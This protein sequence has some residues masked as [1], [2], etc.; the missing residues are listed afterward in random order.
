M[1]LFVRTARAMAMVLGCLACEI[2]AEEAGADT[3]ARAL[4]TERGFSYRNDQRQ[5]PTWSVHVFK[6]DR[7]RKDLF[8]TS[9]TG[10]P[11]RIGMSTVVE[12]IQTL[13]ASWGTP[14]AAVNGDFYTTE[15]DYRGDPRDVQI[16]NGELISAPAG[17]ASFWMDAD[18]EPHTANVE[19]NLRVRWP[20][21]SL[22]PLGLNELRDSEMVV[23]YS[24]AIGRSTRSS[25]GVELV[26][27]NAPGE[28]WLPLQVGRTIKARVAS[29]HRGGDTPVPRDGLVLSI[30][31]R[32]PESARNR[33]PGDEIQLE[34]RTTP[35]L[36]GVETALG[37]GPTLVRAGKPQTW[38]NFQIRHPRSAMGWNKT[39]FFL[40]QVDGRQPD[41]SVGMTFPELAKYMAELGCEEA[42]N[43][44]G[45]GSAT[46]W[47]LG[48]VVNSPSEGRQRPGANALVVMR[49]PGVSEARRP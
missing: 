7:S 16:R 43:L 10:L 18:G 42:I 21:G 31:S 37:G 27:T 13:P 24:S 39:H 29:V 15:D 17:H 19:S 48:Q 40:V 3:P 11:E 5:D 9:T 44:D 20:D 4:T 1:P 8:L 28:G 32:M 38:S 47:V 12:Q 26:L 49:R 34:F 14:I 33:Q 45:G 46:M 22:H 41:L 2:R 30:G 6:V 36:T 23:L 25:G 35:D